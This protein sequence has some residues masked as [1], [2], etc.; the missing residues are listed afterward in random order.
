MALDLA[1]PVAIKLGEE[2]ERDVSY[3][4]D[5]VPTYGHFP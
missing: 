1:S 5:G 3:Y 4:G 2:L